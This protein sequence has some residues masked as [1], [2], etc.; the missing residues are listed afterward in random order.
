[1]IWLLLL[2]GHVTD[3]EWPFHVTFRLVVWSCLGVNNVFLQRLT[4]RAYALSVIA[5]PGW[6]VAQVERHPFNRIPKLRRTLVC[7]AI[8]GFEPVTFRIKDER[9][10]DWAIHPRYSYQEI[11]VKKRKKQF[12]MPY[13]KSSKTVITNHAE[14][15]TLTSIN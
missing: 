11:K 8:P 3:E 5:K 1:M 15:Q 6:W 2:S 12:Y 4:Q 7:Y 14:K 9:S 10:T 13:N